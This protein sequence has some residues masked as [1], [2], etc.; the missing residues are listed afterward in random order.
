MLYRESAYAETRVLFEFPDGPH[1]EGLFRNWL[2][3]LGSHYMDGEVYG[4]S[5]LRRMKQGEKTWRVRL[6]MSYDLHTGFWFE[7]YAAPAQ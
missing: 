7:A 5:V 1:V 3:C 4:G 6:Y 2:A